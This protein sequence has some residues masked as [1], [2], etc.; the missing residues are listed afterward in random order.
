MQGD[1]TTTEMSPSA[2]TSPPASPA[3]YR[4]QQGPSTASLAMQR[5]KRSSSRITDGVASRSSDEGPQTAVK[6]GT[7]YCSAIVFAWNITDND[8]HHSCSSAT[9]LEA[10]RSWI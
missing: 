10:D 5:A 2:T 8:L 9:A 1:T 3:L 7:Y 4:H 6:V